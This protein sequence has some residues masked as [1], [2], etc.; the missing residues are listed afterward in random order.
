MTLCSNV[1]WAADTNYRIALPNEDARRLAEQDDYASL[2]AADQLGQVMRTRGVFAGYYEAPVLFRP[3]Y[4]YDNGT[5]NFDSS[6]KQ[7]IPAYTDRILYAGYDVRS[8]SGLLLPIVDLD[9]PRRST[10]NDINAPSSTPRII[11]QVSHLA[12]ML[13]ARTHLLTS[14]STLLSEPAFAQS[15][16]PSEKLFAKRSNPKLRNI[17]RPSPWT[18]SWRG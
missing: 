4:K 3:T 6:E 18:T 14:Q 7:R 17:R 10:Y 11:G 13:A 9:S 1:I 16:R 2:L 15:I 5:D 12:L 8:V